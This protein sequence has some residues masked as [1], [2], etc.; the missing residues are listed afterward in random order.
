MDTFAFVSLFALTGVSVMIIANPR[1][2][3]LG[4]QNRLR[5]Y[6]RCAELREG[7]EC[8]TRLPREHPATGDSACKTRCPTG[9]D[10]RDGLRTGRGIIRVCLCSLLSI[11]GARTVNLRLAPR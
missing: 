5:S 7:W 2:L 10:I 4:Q 9:W 3:D 6:L 1:G 11:V 8:L